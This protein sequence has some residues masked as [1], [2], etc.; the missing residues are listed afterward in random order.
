[1]PPGA[2]NELGLEYVADTMGVLGW[3]RGSSMGPQKLR[4]EK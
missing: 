1:M 2:T 4:R 3:A